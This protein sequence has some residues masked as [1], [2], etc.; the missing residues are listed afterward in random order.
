MLGRRRP[1]LGRGRL[2]TLEFDGGPPMKAIALVPGTTK[3]RLVERPE[4]RIEQPDQV[5]LRVIMV[6]ICGTDREEASGGRAIAPPGQTDLVIGHEMLGR[7]VAAGPS[8]TAV[9][10]GDLAVLSVRRPCGQCHECAIGFSDMCSSGE[11][12]DRGIRKQ[13]GYQTELVVDSERYV[14]KI[15]PEVGS[16]GVL[17][18]PMSISQKAITE[19]AA[20]QTI[21]LPDA[22]QPEAWL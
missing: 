1:N 13:D 22:G 5:K 20:L 6:G 7:V 21:R 15:P 8:V 2:A 4:P 12:V 16:T 14:V 3:L 17:A 9:Q 19:V 11:Y 18:E 10:P